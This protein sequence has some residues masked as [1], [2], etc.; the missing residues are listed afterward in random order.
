MSELHINNNATDA[1]TILLNDYRQR[2]QAFHAFDDYDQMMKQMRESAFEKIST[3]NEPLHS[4]ASRLFLIAD[5]GFFLF[6]VCEWKID[7][8]AEALIHSIEVKNPIALANNAR[9]LVE[10]LAALVAIAKELDKLEVKLH[11]QGQDIPIYQALEKAETFIH[12]V[13]YGKSPKVATEPYERAFHVNDYIKA[14]KEEVNDIEDVY[15]F[16]CEYVHPNHGSNALVSTGQLANGRLNPPEEFHRETLDR[17]RSYCTH[18]M[19]FLKEHEVEYRSIIIKLNNLFELCLVNGAKVNN[20]FAI[21]APLPAGDGKSRETAF[22]FR[23]ARTAFEA[24]AL[25]YEFL[26]K[27]D[28][29]VRRKE[30]GGFGDGVIYDVYDTD[31]G[32]I[33]FEVPDRKI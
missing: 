25:C 15:D 2:R 14:L 13:Y 22:S 10:H 19:L 27:E 3:L 20:V 28:Y 6:G 17:L 26:K 29:I 9:A 33:W 11:G 31:K 5:K 23:M 18:C 8:I 4:I 32:K 21:K 12:R 24:I 1:A 30:F 7:Y 16:L